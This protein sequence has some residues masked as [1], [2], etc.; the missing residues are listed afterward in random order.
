MIGHC[1]LFL[2]FNFGCYVKVGDH[3]ALEGLLFSVRVTVGF[4]IFGD[5]S[6]FA[7]MW[8]R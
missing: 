7:G 5:F 8:F 4:V 6:D 1:G 3:S 2:S